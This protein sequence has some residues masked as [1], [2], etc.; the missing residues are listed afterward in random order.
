[1]ENSMKLFDIEPIDPNAKMYHADN[2]EK[3][4]D[5][6]APFLE[7]TMGKVSLGLAGAALGAGAVYLYNKSQQADK[8]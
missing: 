3:K 7:T 4:G 1:M 8:A 6:D 2:E 5:K